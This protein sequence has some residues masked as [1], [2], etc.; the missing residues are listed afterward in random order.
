MMNE[1]RKSDPAI[2]A[3]R[4]TNNANRKMAAEPVERGPR[5]TRTSKARAGRSA[6]YACHKRWSAYVKQQGRGR[7]NGSLRCSTTS[8]SIFC[9]CR[10]TRSSAGLLPEWME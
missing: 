2:V 5:G 7:R 1:P 9:G 3:G 8:T 4:P 10:S 6:G